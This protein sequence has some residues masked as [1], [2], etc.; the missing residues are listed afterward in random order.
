MATSDVS[1][2]SK[3][4]VK[5]FQDLNTFQKS[6]VKDQLM[7]NDF[8]AFDTEFNMNKDEIQLALVQIATFDQNVF[9]F[10]VLKCPDIIVELRKILESKKIKKVIHDCLN[11]SKALWTTHAIQMDNVFD[12]KLVQQ[13]L[14]SK[15]T[16]TVMKHIKPTGLETLCKKYVIY[17]NEDLKQRTKEELKQNQA[18]FLQRNRDGS[19]P[20]RMKDYAAQDVTVL[21]DLYKQMERSLGDMQSLYERLINVSLYACLKGVPCRK[22][23]EKDRGLLNY[24]ASPELATLVLVSPTMTRKPY[25]RGNKAKPRR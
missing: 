5:V 16:Q 15:Q 18:Y 4:N 7:Q 25:R 24:V 3:V 17:I 21:V 2:R 20:D 22:R 1:A 14:D 9:L 8:L 6:G 13:I 12:T 11:D 10:D 23:Y 19:I